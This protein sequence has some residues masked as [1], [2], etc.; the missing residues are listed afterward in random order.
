MGLLFPVALK[1]SCSPSPKRRGG[2]G[3]RSPPPPGSEE[4]SPCASP[5]SSAGPSQAHPTSNRSSPSTRPTRPIGFASC[6]R[7]SCTAGAACRSRRGRPPREASLGTCHAAAHCVCFNLEHVSPQPPS[8]EYV[9]ARELAQPVERTLPLRRA[10]RPAL[11]R[12]VDDPRE[13]NAEP[14]D[15]DESGGKS[16]HPGEFGDGSARRQRGRTTAPTIFGSGSGKR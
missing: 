11:P 6:A 8:P 12:L 16:R 9:F 14:F 3:V 15:H 5:H 10:A 1:L 4:T 7:P 2:R 13:L